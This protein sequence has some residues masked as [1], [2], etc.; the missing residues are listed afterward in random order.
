MQKT[1]ESQ[2]ELMRIIAMVFIV[3]YHL[4]L[5]TTEHLWGDQPIYQGIQIPIH[6]GVLLFVM[7][8]GY[9]GIKPTFRGGGRLLIMVAV[10]FIPL[11]LFFDI[12]NEDLFGVAKDFLI[13][14][15]PRYWFFRDYLFL[16]LFSP[17]INNY[18][19]DASLKQRFYLISILAF[20]AIWVGT[21]RGC[22]ALIEGK[23]LTNFILLYVV[24]NTLKVYRDKWDKVPSWILIVL[25]LVINAVILLLWM[26]NNDN[27]IGT[28]IWTVAFPYCSPL[29]YVNAILVFM[30]IGKMKFQSKSVNWMA[31]S[32][33]AVYLIH[34]HLIV[35]NNVI[36]PGANQ[37]LAF[38]NNTPSG[39]IPLFFLYAIVIFCVCI[40]ID[41]ILQ[42]LWTFVG[43]KC[44]IID[45]RI[46][47]RNK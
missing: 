26:P 46:N 33:F 41:K 34:Y 25:F 12:K 32:A 27:L 45:E 43:N 15:Y 47:E 13:V 29:L 21:S 28:V 17:V 24:G 37:I 20:M 36:K 5:D 44:A 9:F 11:A 30:M 35:F 8:S 18:L 10:Y 1:R 42:P 38:C 4:F 39:V 7:I 3:F 6:F 19:K 40:L 16:F 2:F 14:S 22:I 23:N 31:A